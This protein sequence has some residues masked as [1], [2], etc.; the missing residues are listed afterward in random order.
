MAEIGDG[1]LGLTAGQVYTSIF[2]LFYLQFVDLFC[3]WGLSVF[4]SVVS[5]DL[6]CISDSVFWRF[7]YQGIV[8]IDYNLC[9]IISLSS[10]SVK[11][12]KVVKD[13]CV[14]P[15]DHKNEP[16]LTNKVYSINRK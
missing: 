6:P 4:R 9:V 2:I 13:T 3:V 8:E 14:R 1:G 16:N 7:F 12:R 5:L 10:L 11:R 15:S